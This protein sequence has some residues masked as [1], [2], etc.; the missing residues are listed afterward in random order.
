MDLDNE[1]FI[2]PIRKLIQYYETGAKLSAQLDL[3]QLPGMDFSI[4]NIFYRTKQLFQVE[5]NLIKIH[6]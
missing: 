5:S 3:L 2:N 6:Q 1:T 4:S